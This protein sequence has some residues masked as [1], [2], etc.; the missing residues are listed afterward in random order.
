MECSRF[1]AL[2][3]WSAIETDPHQLQKPIIFPGLWRT[4]K[5]KEAL[6]FPCSWN[7]MLRF[8]KEY[9][10]S[11]FPLWLLPR[12]HSMIRMGLLPISR[13]YLPQLLW[14]ESE[15]WG[16]QLPSDGV[17]LLFINKQSLLFSFLLSSLS[18][19][20]AKTVSVL[21]SKYQLDS[22]SYN[23]IKDKLEVTL[24]CIIY[25]DQRLQKN[26]PFQNMGWSPSNVIS[27]HGWKAGCWR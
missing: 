4:K 10:L 3:L 22:K 27:Q 23:K 25:V 9:K 18:I 11:Y 20:K 2:N 8:P 6:G 5:G 16:T 7:D 21:G 12:W 26:S 19:C 14:W 17:N 24:S 13:H 1:V 15:S